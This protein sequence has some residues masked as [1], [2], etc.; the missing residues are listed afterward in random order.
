MLLCEDKISHLA[1]LVLQGLKQ[2][3]RA[4]LLEEGGKVLREIKRT[5][6]DAVKA[7]EEVDQVVRA[8]LSSYSRPIIE[9]SPEWDVL[10]GKFFLEE[11]RKRKKT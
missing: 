6:G 2:D 3:Q 1:H 5:I 7:E 4:Y 11:L 8:K 10:Y 9:G